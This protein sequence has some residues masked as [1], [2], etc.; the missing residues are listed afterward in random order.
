MRQNMH[1]NPDDIDISSLWSVVKRSGPRILGASGLIGLA[2]FAGL[3]L[4]PAKYASEA[5]IRIGTQGLNDIYRP[6]TGDAQTSSE[7]AAIK[8]DK[9]AVASQ[10][11]A[12]RSRDLASRLTTEMKLNQRSEFNSAV[13]NQGFFSS[14]T[15]LA[16][17]QTRKVC[18]LQ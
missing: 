1:S 15:G 13:G 2:T 17:W 12:L 11:V 7:S 5:Q 4:V 18:A 3:S 16:A 9:E 14:L 10:V 6:K 8:V